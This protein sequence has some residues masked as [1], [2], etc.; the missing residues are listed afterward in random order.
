LRIL[1]DAPS[2]EFFRGYR[3]Y[4]LCAT[5][6]WLEKNPS[7][8]RKF[9][10]AVIRA[11]RAIRERPIEEILALLPPELRNEDPTVDIEVMG[12]WRDAFTADGVI[13]PDAIEAVRQVVAVSVEKVRTA[14]IDLRD[15]YTNEFVT[16]LK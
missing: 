5:S 1:L 8:A 6:A 3:T 16:E 12:K 9:A 7:T 11:S 10:R 15:V 13:P 4:G 14:K 2:D